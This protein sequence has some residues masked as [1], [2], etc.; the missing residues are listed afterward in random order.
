LLA[1]ALAEAATD[2]L[3]DVYTLALENDP[4]INIARYRLDAG[5]AGRAIA[6][7]G[8]LPQATASGQLTDNHITFNETGDENSY[9][10]ERY[11]V[12][13]R[14]M[15]FDWRRISANRRA[16]RIVD[17]RESELLDALGSLSVDVTERY[18]DVLLADREVALLEAE[19]T[20]V[21]EQLAAAE[22]LRE[23][24]L[25]PVTDLLETRARLDAV[26]SEIIRAENEA[27]LAREELVVL[28]GVPVN[29]LAA[30]REDV[31]LPPVGRP[32]EHWVELA[33]A[34]NTMLV[35]K[36]DAVE[37]ARMGVEEQRGEFLPTADLVLSYQ[38]S[39]VGFDNLQAQ[40][41]EVEY[42]GL[43]FSIPLFRGGA[44]S[45]RLREAWAEYYISREEE[46]GARREVRKRVRGAWL[47]ASA[48]RRRVAAARLSV[49]SAG[50]SYRA[51]SRA[52]GL[53]TATS[54]E[55]LEALHNQTR[56][57][58]DYWQAVYDYLTNWLRLQYEA[59]AIDDESLRTLD[60]LLSR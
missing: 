35:S 30:V 2:T 42:L 51:I 18:M 48:A 57:R 37:A 49:E 59:G 6:R 24:K 39:D 34:D 50:T 29:E 5:E 54:T 16:R 40:D 21:E 8:L 15:L 45:G 3:L 47:N 46:E 60:S 4:D 31:Q 23:R 27:A 58:R 26:R 41:R 25:A 52:R 17:Q 1:S 12:Q 53:G 33:M 56:A 11:A 28:T 13:V 44:S 7:G 20:L 19:R 43:E 10:G 36:R 9:P 22:A 14:Q 55:V 32:I 38:Q